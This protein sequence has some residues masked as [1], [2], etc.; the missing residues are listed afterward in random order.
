M[1]ASDG[2]AAL[3]LLPFLASVLL[4]LLSVH[5]DSLWMDEIQTHSVIHRPFA[6]FA[7][8]LSSRGDAASGMPLYFLCEY[9]WCRL[10]GYGEFALRSMNYLAALLVLFGALGLISA[11]KL[12]RWSLLFFAAN[13]MFLYYMNE[14]RPYAFL[15]ACGIWGVLFLHRCAAVPPGAPARR[16]LAGF[17][18]CWFAACTLHMMAVFAGVAYGVFL[19]LLLRQRQPVFKD[20]WPVWLVAAP[21]FAA[22]GLY[23]VR[24]AFG[25]PEL[26]F[27]TSP[28]S[29]IFQIA[30]YFAGLG[31]LG[32]ARNSFREMSIGFS[33]RVAVELAAAALA[34]IAFLACCI[35]ARVWRNRRIVA[36][37]VCTLAALLVFLAANIV[38]KTR[39]WERH[40]IYLVPGLVF[41]LALACRDIQET[42]PCR[43]AKAVVFAVL[44]VNVLSG[45][46]IAVLDEFRKEDYRGAVQTALASAPDHVFFQ[47]SRLVFRYYGLR[48]NWSFD[49]DRESAAPIDGNINISIATWPELRD[50][51]ARASGRTLLLLF[52]R[53]EY[54]PAGF[55][56]VLSSLGRHVTGFSIVDAADIP[57][58][59]LSPESNPMWDGRTH[60]P[61]GKWP[62]PPTPTQAQ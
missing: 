9:A 1:K 11:A 60:V 29:G 53:A 18:A 19:L 56:P 27:P 61:T 32:W 59:A 8:E 23:F 3:S 2:R 22:L 51:L 48:G 31:G 46:N 30:Y 34:Y 57:P 45:F 20:H 39:F 41:A 38:L 6:E 5:S 10:F 14:A 26:G 12:P 24:F 49:I 33:P 35:R 16:A 58:D 55:Y 43:F 21:F 17:F 15:Y 44:A 62:T 42:L 4:I 54:D 52:D 13:P 36:A 37:L 25:A 50:F 28:L 7:R 40:V 47:G